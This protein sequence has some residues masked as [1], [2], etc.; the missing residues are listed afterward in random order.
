MYAPRCWIGGSEEFRGGAILISV[1]NNDEQ[2]TVE[3]TK[4]PKAT[5]CVWLPSDCRSVV[6][7]MSMMDMPLVLGRRKS[8]GCQNK[9]SFFL[10][11]TCMLL[12]LC[13]QGNQRR[14]ARQITWLFA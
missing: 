4:Q 11:M 9:S 5:V 1:A 14:A 6:C 8:A 12:L 3:L 7:S 13:S 2:Q 10:L